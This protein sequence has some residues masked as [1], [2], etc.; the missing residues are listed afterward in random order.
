MKPT[1]RVALAAL[2]LLSNA[3]SKS[4]AAV[5]LRAPS[6][7]EFSAVSSVLEL[8]CGGLDCHG[9]PARSLRVFGV[10]GLRWDGRDVPGG[11]DTTPEEVEASYQSLIS[12]DPERLSRVSADAGRGAETW[13]P[14]SKGRGREA[15]EGGTRLVP[16][17][18]AD[19]C[20]LSWLS[21][22]VDFDACASDDFGPEPRAGEDW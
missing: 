17:S 16:G 3:C 12:I 21:G 9:G 18:A 6:R 11:R 10:Y 19:Q 22:K 5:E 13:L 14:L 1:G 15:H 20:V 8:R 2:A 4:E 7:V